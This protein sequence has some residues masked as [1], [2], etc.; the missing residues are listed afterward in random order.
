LPAWLSSGTRQRTKRLEKSASEGD[1]RIDDRSGGSPLTIESGSDSPIGISAR[2]RMKT[3]RRFRNPSRSLFLSLARS[4]TTVV[5][6]SITPFGLRFRGARGEVRDRH[7]IREG[8]D[9]RLGLARPGLAVR[10]AG[11]G[12]IS[13]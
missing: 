1:T 7:R 11:R 6:A 5:L 13:G 2:G 4:L 12:I 8:V 10:D 3:P 9:H